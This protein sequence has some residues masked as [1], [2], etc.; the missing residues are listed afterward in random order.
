MYQILNA[1]T[2]LLEDVGGCWNNVLCA[3]LE[4]N[5][6]F[7]VKNLHLKKGWK[8]ENLES[9]LKE[10]DFDYDSRDPMIKEGTVWLSDG[11]WL[12]RETE[13]NYSEQWAEWWEEHRIPPV[14]NFLS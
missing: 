11:S 10:L 6:E 3:H 2:E 7:G 1:K 4:I 5:C 9:F 13:V 14:P 8:A 12:S